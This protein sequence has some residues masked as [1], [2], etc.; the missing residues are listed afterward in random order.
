MIKY[1]APA[2]LIILIAFIM[3][4][5]WPTIDEKHKRKISLILLLSTIF[6]IIGLIALIID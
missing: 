2:I 3:L 4:Y 1:L 5:K 6:M